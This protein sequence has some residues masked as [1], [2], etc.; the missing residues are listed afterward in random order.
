[1]SCSKIVV[2]GSVMCRAH[3]GDLDVGVFASLV[4]LEERKYV[5]RTGDLCCSCGRYLVRLT[6]SGLQLLSWLDRETAQAELA[7]A[8]AA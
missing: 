5:Q 1:M 2:D 4:A 7:H 3:G 6:V 8:A